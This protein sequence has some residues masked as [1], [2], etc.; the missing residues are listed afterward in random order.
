MLGLAYLFLRGFLRLCGSSSVRRL[1]LWGLDL[2]GELGCRPGLDESVFLQTGEG[3]IRLIGVILHGESAVLYLPGGE[4]HQR[5]AF[6]ILSRSFA[7]LGLFFRAIAEDAFFG[8]N[9]QFWLSKPGI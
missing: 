3:D 7:G 9:Q 6:Q 5:T 1:L 2:L 8:G 4:N